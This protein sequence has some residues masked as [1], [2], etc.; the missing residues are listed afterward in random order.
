MKICS[1][2]GCGKKYSANGGCRSHRAR[3][4]RYGSLTGVPKKK[5]KPK[6]KCSFD[7]CES[8][9][10]AKGWC[11][12]H[13]QY[14]EID[15]EIKGNNERK[16]RMLNCNR[17]HHSK[18]FCYKHFKSFITTTTLNRYKFLIKTAKQRGIQVGLT[19]N[20]FE[21]VSTGECHYCSTEFLTRGSGLDRINNNLGYTID[22]V[23]RCCTSCNKFKCN[24]VSVE[25]F[26]VLV[27]K[28]QELRGIKD[29]WGNVNLLELYNFAK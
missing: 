24:Y 1:V 6:V 18:D 27:E 11:K 3:L 29:I 22:N 19:F 28:L 5:V 21:T 25:E 17:R 26:K 23:L 8:F 2:E 7:E 4:K 14:F 10:K 20:E 15:R 12:K 16:C 9:Q 13:Y